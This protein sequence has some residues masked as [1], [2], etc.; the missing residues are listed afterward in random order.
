LRSSD[1]VVAVCVD[2]IGCSIVII[3]N[4]VEAVDFLTNY[5]AFRIS[6]CETIAVI[7]QFVSTVSACDIFR[8]WLVVLNALLSASGAGQG[9]CRTDTG[10]PGITRAVS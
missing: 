9:P 4:A 1:R 6:I 5:H 3:I 10:K 8:Y 7:V 2:T